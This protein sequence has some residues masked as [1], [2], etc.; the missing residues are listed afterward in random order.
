MLAWI[1]RSP[2]IATGRDDAKYIL[3]ARSLR[4]FHYR[5]IWRIGVPPHGEYPPGFPAA[6]A[7]WSRLFGERYDLLVALNVLCSALALLIVYRTIRALASEEAALLA[8][9][10]LVVNPY[11]LALAG[12]LESEPLFLLLN[13]GAL[14]LLARDAPGPAARAGAGALA[15]AA[16]LTRSAGLPLL[17]AIMVLWLFERRWRDVVLLGIASA[18]TVGAWFR[19]TL[20]HAERAV[21]ESYVGDAQLLVRNGPL[22]AIQRAGTRA[23][24]YFVYRLNVVL[25]VPAFAG[26]AIDNVFFAALVLIGMTIG[27]AIFWRRWRVAALCLLGTAAMLMLWTWASRRFLLPVLPLLVPCFILGI[28]ALAA[29]RRPTW[30][31]P[32]TALA[33]LV[34]IVTGAWRTGAIVHSRSGC[35]RGA[36]P[37]SRACVSGDPADV[38]AAAVWMRDSLP[39]DA[40]VLSAKPEPVYYYSQRQG[41]ALGAILARDSSE[42]LSALR[43]QGIGWILLGSV[44]SSEVSRLAPRLQVEC[45]HLAVAAPFSPRTWVFRI[46][47]DGEP[48]DGA[49]CAAVELYRQA[50]RGRNFVR[51]E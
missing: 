9:A 16:V 36:S 27:L 11:L 44:Q 33:A 3:L 42:M 14:A 10:A 24:D 29:W 39:R 1:T 7:L 37:P 22:M 12:G 45:S 40:R 30:R 26:T 21:G 2:G 8:L 38:L 41:T 4:H 35:V 15:I 50:N 47:E 25:P 13:M 32:A 20:H 43:R 31:V 6:I 51:G 17:A 48:N 5:E 18:L 34:L 23:M 28:G 19:W 49:A 46:R